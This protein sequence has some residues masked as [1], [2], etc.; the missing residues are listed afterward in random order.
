MD[1]ALD[2]DAFNFLRTLGLLND[3]TIL[4]G[5]KPPKLALY[6]TWYVAKHELS[7][8]SSEIDQLEKQGLLGIRRVETGT[9]AFKLFR[10]LQQDF[11]KGESE[12]GA[13]IA[14][15]C[16]NAVLASCDLQVPRMAKQLGF[17]SLD[18][19]DLAIVLVKDSLVPE[20]TVAQRLRPWANPHVGQG[21]P[22]W[23]TNL[24]DALKR[25][26]PLH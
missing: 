23:W 6:T 16:P 24:D 22:N 25:P 3:L 7:S 11:D 18:L 15:S 10:K 17:K 9:A 14:T 12:L 5:A 2:A 8:L 13:W 20:A 26:H 4:A 21:R 1:L 19:G